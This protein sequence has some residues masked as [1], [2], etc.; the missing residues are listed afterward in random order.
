MFN[1]YNVFIFPISVDMTAFQTLRS[2]WTKSHQTTPSRTLSPHL[3]TPIPLHPLS[4][5]QAPAHLFSSMGGWLTL[6]SVLHAPPWLYRHPLP[7]RY[8]TVQQVSSSLTNL[9][10]LH[11]LRQW[12]TDKHLLNC[13]P[14]P[15]TSQSSK[16]MKELAGRGRWVHSISQATLHYFPGGPL[17]QVWTISE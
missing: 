5:T 9:F 17:C 2:L 3:F 16:V 6:P 4:L 12:V 1:K 7:L 15:I 13:H 8:V 11:R 14:S 10:R